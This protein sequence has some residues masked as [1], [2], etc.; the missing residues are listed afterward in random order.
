MPLPELSLGD[1]TLAERGELERAVDGPITAV[2][3]ADKVAARGSRPVT[4][5]S[6]LYLLKLIAWATADLAFYR[7][8]IMIL[9]TE[10]AALVA[11]RDGLYAASE[12]DRR[13]RHIAALNR[14]RD[15]V[16]EECRPYETIIVDARRKLGT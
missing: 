3:I 9:E 6:P 14:Q 12:R 16:L 1:L 10:I 7:Q 5:E 2:M 4:D 8:Q 13:A 11:D 15:S